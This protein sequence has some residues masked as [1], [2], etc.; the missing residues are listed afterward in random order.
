M[1]P[2]HDNGKTPRT[3]C[4]KAQPRPES[5]SRR[6]PLDPSREAIATE[7]DDSAGSAGT[8][9]EN[10]QIKRVV[11]PYLRV[12]LPSGHVS[13]LNHDLSDLPLLQRRGVASSFAATGQREHPDA[14]EQNAAVQARCEPARYGVQTVRKVP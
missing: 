4:A 3:R 7:M 2:L 13:V 9:D 10:A 5:H 14:D 12:Q 6:L 11:F 8:D 1:R